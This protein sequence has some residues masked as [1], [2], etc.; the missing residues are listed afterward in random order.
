MKKEVWKP[1]PTIIDAYGKS[2]TPRGYEVS[3]LG[4]IRSYNN[5]YGRGDKSG[6]RPLLKEPIIISGRPDARGYYQVLLSSGTRGKRKNFRIHVLVMQSFVGPAPEGMVI[7]HYNDVKADNRLENLRYD[8]SSANRLDHRR[9]SAA[10]I[11]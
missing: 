6:Y 10:S 3:N 5:R 8:T 4:R 7:C 1:I 9:N 11:S 2:F